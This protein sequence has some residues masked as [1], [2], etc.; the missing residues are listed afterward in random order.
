MAT[1]SRAENLAFRAD[2]NEDFDTF[3]GQLGH[4]TDWTIV[5]R[6]ADQLSSHSP[7]AQLSFRQNSALSPGVSSL[8]HPSE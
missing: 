1:R 6:R 8:H 4:G 7:A 3:V 5:H 2:H